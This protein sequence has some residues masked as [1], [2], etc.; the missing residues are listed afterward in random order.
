M[1][2]HVLT[3]AGSDSGG[4]AGI[5][6]DLKTFSA[7]GTYGLS[8]ITAITAQNTTGV[9][10]VQV[11]EPSMIEKQLDAV[12]QDIR[13]DAV[14]IGM[15]ANQESIQVIAKKIRQYQPKIVIVDPVMVSTTGS[16]L[17]EQDAVVALRDELFPL[18]TLITPNRYEAAILLDTSVDALEDITKAAQKIKEFTAGEVL[19]K[20]GHAPDEEQA[21][22]VLSTG[23]TFRAE[24]IKTNHD[25][26]TGCSLSSAIAAL[27]AKGQ[28]LVPA[29]QEAK[30]FVTEGL[31]HAY[32]IGAGAS[33]IHHFYQLWKPEDPS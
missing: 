16:R 5:Q 28:S 33:P 21:I 32:P 24:R 30:E 29:I 15:V 7:L 20:G 14:K 6:A 10:G 18:A 13:I 12:F 2:K 1:I 31:R 8:V 19:V 9:I 25:H 11:I 4:G 23:D 3:I 27:M 17:L 22:D 26:G